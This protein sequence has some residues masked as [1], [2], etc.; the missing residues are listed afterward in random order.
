MRNGTI[1]GGEKKERGEWFSMTG[2]ELNQSACG[3]RGEP[4]EHSFLIL[5]LLCGSR[6]LISLESG[7][8]DPVSL[9]GGVVGLKEIE[10]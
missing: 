3:I 10:A 7:G 8:V 5:S 1:L 4:L 9:A 2:Y 6:L